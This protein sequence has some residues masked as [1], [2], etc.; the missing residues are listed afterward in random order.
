M[1][2]LDHKSKSSFFYFGSLHGLPFEE[3]EGL[4]GLSAYERYI[5]WGGYCN[6]G[7]ILFP[8]WHRAYVLGIEKGTLVMY[9]CTQQRRRTM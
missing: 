6:H 3:R 4:D 7:N 8:T 5:Y 2:A 1:Q 9:H